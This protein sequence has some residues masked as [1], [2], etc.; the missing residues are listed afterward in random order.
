LKLDKSKW[1]LASW[2][3]GHKT[4]IFISFQ[5]YRL[6]YI[7]IEHILMRNCSMTRKI[8][9]SSLFVILVLGL[10]I[11]KPFEYATFHDFQRNVSSKKI[12]DNYSN[13]LNRNQRAT[14][15]VNAVLPEEFTWELEN[16]LI[17]GEGIVNCNITSPL[18]ECRVD[19]YFRTDSNTDEVSSA[20]SKSTFVFSGDG[21]QNENFT[22]MIGL[23]GFPSNQSEI[24]WTLWGSYSL[25]PGQNE[26]IE[27]IKGSILIIS[28]YW[29]LSDTNKITPEDLENETTSHEN[30]TYLII[31]FTFSSI[32]LVIGAII[33]IIHL[34]NRR[35]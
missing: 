22:L 23:I 28:H 6:C 29:E 4:D 18:A 34:K 5:V 3:S 14:V 16:N 31:I 11:C 2:K 17:S 19:L 20:I 8:V 30:Y 27:E 9:V 33:V 1:D 35:K 21:K 15:D 26:N 32:V 7:F 25:G 24:T 12:N 13:F 10:T